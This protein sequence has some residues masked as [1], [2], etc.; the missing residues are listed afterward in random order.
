MDKASFVIIFLL[1]CNVLSIG[2]IS[3]TFADTSSTSATINANIPSPD[4]GGGGGG[5]GGGGDNNNQKT[6]SPPTISN[7]SS[8]PGLSSAEV[9]WQAVDDNSVK[10]CS[11]NYDSGT[12]P[13]FPQ[14]NQVKN[15]NGD[16]Y[17]VELSQLNSSTYYGFEIKCGDDNSQVV[18]KTGDFKTKSS[19]KIDLTLEATPEKRKN[20]NYKFGFYLFIVNPE[21]NKVLLTINSSTNKS[22]SFST[23]NLTTGISSTSKKLQAILKG[24]SYLASKIKISPY[25]SNDKVD[26]KFSNVLQA[27]DISGTKLK[28]NF[29]D[30]LDLSALTS[31]FNTSNK[32]ADLNRDGIVDAVDISILFSNFNQEGVEL[33][34]NINL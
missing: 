16:K 34:K 9:S 29:V 10:S 11:F 30:V 5:G 26:L 22:G 15:P 4:N 14:S 28:D 25:K 1:I 21:N 2:F 12:S 23:N 17:K 8:T 6:D 19:A 3:I 33:P 13:P 20:Q 32:N 27:G 31:K 18:S 7:V 24:D